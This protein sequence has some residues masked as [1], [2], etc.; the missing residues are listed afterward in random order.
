MYKVGYQIFTLEWTATEWS[1]LT[2]LI[3]LYA[4]G[5]FLLFHGMLVCA[6]IVEQSS[7]EISWRMSRYLL[8][9]RMYI[10]WLEAP[11]RLH[12]AMLI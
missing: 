8:D 11:V 10:F 7:E 3:A 1:W 2:L 6:A 12:K 5:T 9:S 4:V